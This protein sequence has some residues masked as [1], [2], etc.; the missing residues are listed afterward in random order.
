[1]KKF[2]LA[3]V[4]VV[5]L[6][7]SSVQATEPCFHYKKVTVPVVVTEYVTQEVAYTKEVVKY[8]HCNKP[9][10]VKVTAYKEIEVAVKKTTYVTKLVKVYD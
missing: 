5:A 4:A 8:D 10:T 3:L 7:G 9:Y 1:M 2:M 6:V